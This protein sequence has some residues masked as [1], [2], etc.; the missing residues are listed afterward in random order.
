MHEWFI[1]NWDKILGVLVPTV[2]AGI[3]AWRRFSARIEKT[4]RS[5][6]MLKLELASMKE[7]QGKLEE[8]VLHALDRLQTKVDDIVDLKIYV[9]KNDVILNEIKDDIRE[10]KGDVKLLMRR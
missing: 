10:L 3:A 5:I 9:E 2:G 8:G 6:E 1:K 7:S 4:E